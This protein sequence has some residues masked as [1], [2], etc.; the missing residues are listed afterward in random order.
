MFVFP[1]RPGGDEIAIVL[2]E[3]PIG[4]AVTLGGRVVALVR[5]HPYLFDG[6]RLEVTVSMGIAELEGW[7]E[8]EDFLRSADGALYE[9]KR[10]GRDRFAVSVRRREDDR[11]SIKEKP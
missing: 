4:G 8:S 6:K 9:A 3:T 7:M 11:L 5:G 10:T 1:A 2:P